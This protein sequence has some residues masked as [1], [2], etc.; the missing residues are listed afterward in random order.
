[1]KLNDLTIVIVTLKSEEK[2]F[3]C[4]NSI[5]RELRVIIVENSSNMDFKKNIEKKYSNVRCILTGKNKGYSVA[6]N[7]GLK[8]VNSKFAL[9]LNPDTVINQKSIEHFF[10]FSNQNEDFCRQ[11]EKKNFKNDKSIIG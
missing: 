9:V 6:N 8:Q 4:L 7:L 5:P 11:E 2:I 3:S 10:S 1:M